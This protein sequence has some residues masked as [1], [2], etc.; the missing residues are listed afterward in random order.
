MPAAFSHPSQRRTG[1]SSRKVLLATGL[2]V[3][4]S[5]P[6]FAGILLGLTTLMPACHG[7]GSSGSPMSGCVLAGIDLNPLLD[8][9]TPAILLALVTVPV[10]VVLC[11]IGLLLPKEESGSFPCQGRCGGGADGGAGRLS[12]GA[13]GP[14]PLPALPVRHPVQARRAHIRKYGAAELRLRLW[15]MRQRFRLGRAARL[16]KA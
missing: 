15:R 13:S 7:G 14:H 2:A 4:V 12:H 1:P 3:G 11:L 16:R 9:L 10:G 8:L 6:V 5:L